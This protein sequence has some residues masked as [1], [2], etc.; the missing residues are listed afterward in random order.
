MPTTG[1]SLGQWSSCDAAPTGSVPHLPFVMGNFVQV[2]LIG[3]GLP[4]S[5]DPHPG[6]SIRGL[7]SDNLG[8][9]R[10]EH[11]AFVLVNG[12]LALRLLGVLVASKDIA[13]AKWATLGT[14][15]LV[16]LNMAF[17]FALSRSSQRQKSEGDYE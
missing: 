5:D 11:R 2:G 14:L 15:V 3:T 17:V 12:L 8:R 6:S 9:V 13:T 10:P 16:A 4:M 7:I 1:C